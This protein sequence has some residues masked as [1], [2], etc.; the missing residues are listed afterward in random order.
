MLTSVETSTST[1]ETSTT[2]VV[3]GIAETELT[4][5]EMKTIG[6]M[7]IVSSVS[8][9]ILLVRHGL[10]PRFVASVARI[11]QPLL[12]MIQLERD[13]FLV[14]PPTRVTASLNSRKECVKPFI[15]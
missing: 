8:I 13:H 3:M 11:T 14:S 10:M 4:S 6:G 5:V 2:K 7:V 15:I 12:T 1:V 9:G